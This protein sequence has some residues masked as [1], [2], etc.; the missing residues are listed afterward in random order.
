MRIATWNVNSVRARLEHL[1]KWL[2]AEQP[3]IV[4]LQEL[5]V[6]PEAFPYDALTEIG[7]HAAVHGQKTYNGVAILAKQPLEDVRIGFDD[8]GEE[9]PQARIVRAT[10]GGIRV[11]NV[12]V[13][14][15]KAVGDPKY[16]Y[17]LRWL[18]RLRAML[19]DQEDPSGDLVLLGDFNIVPEPRDSW[20]EELW[21]GNVF[22]TEDERRRLRSFLEWGLIDTLRL[23]DQSDG[24]FTWWDYRG[25]SYQLRKGLRI[26]HILASESLAARSESC[27]VDRVPRKWKK[28]SDHAPVVAT[29]RD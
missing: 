1:V 20:D 17:K 21:E 15:G 16:D 25:L 7:Y 6:V 4:A 14:N 9:D 12:Y 8:G 13:V 23:H 26:D 5:K 27:V 28:P 29:F 11:I 10:V 18:D 22:C 2:E 3:D 19:G 24:L